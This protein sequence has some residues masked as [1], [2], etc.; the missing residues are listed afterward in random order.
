[1][2]SGSRG[3]VRNQNIEMLRIVAAF[4]VVAFHAGVNPV[5]VYYAGLVV[6]LA[7]S[8][9]FEMGANFQRRR[10]AGQLAQTF[11][12]PFAFWFPV[13]GL[14]NVAKHKPFLLEYTPLG[15][16]AGT[17]IHLWFLPFM[18]LVL[19]GLNQLKHDRIRRPLAV[20][21]ML[22]TLLLVLTSPAWGHQP[23]LVRAPLGQWLHAL[24]AVFI[25]AGLGLSKNSV[26]MRLFIIGV[27]AISLALLWCQNDP[28]Y[29]PL[30]YTVGFA[31]LLVALATPPRWTRHWDVGLISGCMMGVYLMHP[32]ALTVFGSVFGK[33]T[34]V[35]AIMTFLGCT[36]ASLVLRSAAPMLR[37]VLLAQPR[38]AKNT[39]V[40]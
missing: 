22:A 8:P 36:I 13:Y 16:L 4:G 38:P 29:S 40:A 33:G 3:T 34:L 24:V 30:A 23:N 6:F 7:L 27:G 1:M 11:L 37:P 14:V 9:M 19:L 12:L 18:F 10:S 15:V 26:P 35:T 17:S 28:L 5:N 20:V 32:I 2:A 21:A 25:G 31:A 39:A